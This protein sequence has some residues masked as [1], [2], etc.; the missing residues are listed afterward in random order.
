[1]GGRSLASAAYGLLEATRGAVAKAK[2]K[3]MKFAINKVMG[4]MVMRRSTNW[5]M[6][7]PISNRLEICS[8][9]L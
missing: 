9:S 4:K 6:V 2:A 7:S 3:P 5:N 1:M 8:L